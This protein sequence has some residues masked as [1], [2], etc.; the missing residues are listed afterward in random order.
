[1][2]PNGALLTLDRLRLAVTRNEMTKKRD[3]Q[4]EDNMSYA[5]N[6]TILRD[7]VGLR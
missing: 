4:E 3:G 6:A 1:M 2:K 7:V 5:Y